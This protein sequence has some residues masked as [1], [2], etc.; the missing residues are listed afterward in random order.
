LGVGS[1]FEGGWGGGWIR[2]RGEHSTGYGFT[3]M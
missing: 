1:I 2:K 3:E